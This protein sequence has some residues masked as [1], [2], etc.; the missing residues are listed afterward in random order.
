MINSEDRN[1]KI[2]ILKFVLIGLLILSFIIFYLFFQLNFIS[3]DK[4]SVKNYYLVGRRPALIREVRHLLVEYL[5]NPLQ[6]F[7]TLPSIRTLNQNIIN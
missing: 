4:A 3:A 6:Q 1:K 7:L 2:V 5:N